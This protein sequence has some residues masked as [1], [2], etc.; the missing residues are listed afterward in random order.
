MTRR[1][2]STHA[3]LEQVAYQMKHGVPHSVLRGPI[4]L[5]KVQASKTFEYC[6]REAAQIL[7][8][9]AYTRSGHGERVE[10]L[11]REVRVNAIGGG[12]EEILRAL[13]MKEALL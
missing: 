10:R 4:A 11:Y 8:G 13:A 2:E 12:S 7:G 3:L 5:L 6:A 1:V 9:N